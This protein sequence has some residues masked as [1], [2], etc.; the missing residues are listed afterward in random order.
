MLSQKKIKHVCHL[1]LSSVCGDEK[2]KKKTFRIILW[3]QTLM[4]DSFERR[5]RKVRSTVHV[6]L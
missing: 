2:A 6:S 4:K 1:E 5:M 3:K